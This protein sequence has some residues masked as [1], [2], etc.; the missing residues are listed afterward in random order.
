MNKS[1]FFTGQPIFCQLLSLLS[2]Q[3][4]ARIVE[5]NKSDHY[6][7]RFKTWNHLVT[8]LFGV[9]HNCTS[10][11]EVTTG[12]LA[13]EGRL[14][15]LGLM[16]FSKRST[17]SDANKRRDHQVF[18]RIYYQAFERLSA[19]LPDSRLKSR[20]NKLIIVDSTTITLFQ[21]IFTAAGSSPSS[22]KRKG[23]VKVHMAVQS[24]QAVPY[25]VCMTPSSANDTTFLKQL[26]FPKGSYVVF[27]KGYN[28]FHLF[29]RFTKEKVNWV[30]RKREKNVITLIQNNPITEKEKTKG[31]L[32]DQLIILGH[33]SKAIEK[34]QCRLITYWDSINKRT[35]EFITNN[36]SI[37]AST[38]ADIYKR[39]W[40]IELL[41][42]RLKQNLLQQY[43]LGDNQNAI[44]IQIWISLLAD[45]LLRAA[46]HGI[47]RKWSYSN[48]AGLIRMHLMHYTQLK[49]FLE[50]PEKACIYLPSSSNSNQLKL[51]LSG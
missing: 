4:I 31:V 51:F 7:K 40:Q 48:L 46:T 6:C 18:E 32:K 27:D 41:F 21:E 26:H 30:T 3:E 20:V 5:Q 45:L 10:L 13:C 24:E 22:G 43:F 11:R 36:F 44:K 16:H 25:L 34:V 14:Q 37:L 29:N 49:A 19:F 12:M 23:G 9:Y 39:R 33:K 1:T 15:S 35:F 47:K 8:M 38:V 17:L 42:K 2:R 28:S 50:N